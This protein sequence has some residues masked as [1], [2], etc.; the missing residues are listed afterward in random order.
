MIDDFHYVEITAQRRIAQQIK[1]AAARGLPVIVVAIPHRADDAVRANPDLRGR[2][3]S[4]DLDYWATDQL[5][6]IGRKGF[7]LLNV[8]IGDETL[9][10]LAEESLRAPQIMQHLCLMTCQSC[11]IQ[12]VQYLRLDLRLDDGQINE[13]AGRVASFTSAGTVHQILR[14][15]PQVRGQPRTTHAFRGGGTGDIYEV[16]LRAMKQ[17]PPSL[18]FPIADLKERVSRIV[19]GSEALGGSVQNT[20]RHMHDLLKDRIPDERVIE[21]DEVRQTIDVVDP[22]FAYYLRWGTT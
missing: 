19:V 2:V 3:L 1:D 18:S 15:G 4:I 12:G 21:W 16:V 6:E 8:A 14:Q 5:M 10:R 17:N 22:Y 7:P 20:V 11:S 13:V 9:A